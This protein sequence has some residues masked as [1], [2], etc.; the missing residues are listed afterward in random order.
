VA[1]FIRFALFT[2]ILVGLLAFFV[3][4]LVAATLL[5]SIARD[6]GL[7]GDNVSVTVNLFGP[8]LLSGRAESVH[9]EG[10]NV[11]VPHGV[12]GDMDM[13]LSDVSIAD[14]SFSTVSGTLLNLRLSGPGG[15]SVNVRSVDVQGPSN[16]ARANGT[17]GAADARALVQ[18]VATNAGV[19]VD[20]VQLKDGTITL[21]KGNLHTEAAL[22]VSGTALVLDRGGVQSTVLLSPATS[23]DWQLQSVSVTPAGIQVGMTV[24][25][26]GL[27]QTLST[28]SNR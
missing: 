11:N 24:D 10:T 16:R 7:H 4:P 5:G 17:I 13:T 28:A 8:G 18:A 25:A 23:E 20:S 3:V 2:T 12:V 22:R 26:V 27:A 6:A 1:G 14:H 19:P 15:T 9:L 21:I